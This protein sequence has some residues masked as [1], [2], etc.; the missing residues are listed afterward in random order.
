MTATVAGGS[1]SHHNCGG[2]F[3][4]LQMTGP[5]ASSRCFSLQFRTMMESLAVISPAAG[6]ARVNVGTRRALLGSEDSRFRGRL[7]WNRGFFH[8]GRGR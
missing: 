2:P 5:G 4:A 8:R 6:E 1:H 7:S 3:G